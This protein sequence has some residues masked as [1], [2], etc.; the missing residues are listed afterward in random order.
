MP[1]RLYGYALLLSPNQSR[2]LLLALGSNISGN[3]GDPHATLRRAI[4]QLQRYGI[5]IVGRSNLYWTQP[6]GVGRQPYY[7]NAVVVAEAGLAPAELLRTLKRIEGRAGRKLSPPMHARPLDLD[8]LAYGGRRFGWPP[9]RRHNGRLILPHPELQARAFVLVPLGDV[10]PHWRHPVLGLPVK[11][12][13]A[14]LRPADRASVRPS[15][16]FAWHPCEKG[17]C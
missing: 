8:I 1:L 12:M 9:T 16:D 2:A 11:T 4:N 7:L 15:L 5:N 13:L 10:A 6:L 3:W 14:R 17:T